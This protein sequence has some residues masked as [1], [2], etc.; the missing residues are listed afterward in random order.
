MRF[1]GTA[2]FGAL[3]LL[4]AS[5][6]HALTISNSDPKPHKITVTAGGA[7]NEMTID[8]CK[9]ADAQCSS[10]CKV[11]LESGDE[12][13]LKGGETVSIDG[14]VMFIDHSPDADMKDIPDID[15]DAP[16]SGAP[17]Q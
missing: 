10:G 17:A 1:A 11:K 7:S 15:P 13:E 3:A 14:G 12:Y 2:A 5:P 8:S 4:C 6:V 16:A 9:Q